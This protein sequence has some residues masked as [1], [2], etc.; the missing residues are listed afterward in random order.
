MV[1]T[2]IAEHQQWK[3][4][5]NKEINPQMNVQLRFECGNRLTDWRKESF[6]NKWCWEIYLHH[7]RNHF[8][9]FNYMYD[10]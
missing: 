9:I 10:F 2:P 3:R 7:K 6:F 1:P 5:Q 8:P 4:I